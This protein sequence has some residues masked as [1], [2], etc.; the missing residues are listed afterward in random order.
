VFAATKRYMSPSGAMLPLSAYYLSGLD[1]ESGTVSE[2]VNVPGQYLDYDPARGLL[3]TQDWQWS[4]GCEARLELH[5]SAWDG[6]GSPEISDTLVLPTYGGPVHADTRHVLLQ[7]YN[8]G[9]VLSAF[10]IDDNL[11]FVAGPVLSKPNA[12][13]NVRAVDGDTVYLAL[14][15]LL[16]RYTLG[17]DWVLRDATELSGWVQAVRLTSTEAVL[18]LGYAGVL[19][20]DR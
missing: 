3:L 2:P 7:T 1:P 13:P 8:G 18:P 5:A 10:S 20:L 15:G 9:A 17:N 4:S 14:D 12:Y 6:A 11:E 19:R 16:E